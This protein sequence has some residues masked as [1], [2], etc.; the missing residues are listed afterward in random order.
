MQSK[1]RSILVLC[2]AIAACGDT[3]A[4]AATST[5]INYVHGTPIDLDGDG[6]PDGLAI[7]VDGD[8]I[9]DGVDT[10]NDGKVD[11]ALPP[12]PN[13]NGGNSP[14]PTDWTPSSPLPTDDE[15]DPNCRP[16]VV[17]NQRVTPDILIVL[18]RSGSM[19][20]NN[21]WR[22]SVSALQSSINFGLMAFPGTAA[23]MPPPSSD[24]CAGLPLLERLVCQFQNGG[25]SGGWGG[26]ATCEAGSIVVPIEADAAPAISAALDNMA[27]SGNT[28]TSFTLRE[29]HKL[30]G[31]G[32]G[33]PDEQVTPKFV[34]LVTDGEPN[35]EGNSV[36]ALNSTVAAIEEL[37]ADGIRTYVVGYNTQTGQAKQAMD[38][39]AAAGGTGMKEHIAVENEQTLVAALEDITGRAISCTFV[40]EERPD[41]PTYVSVQ[42]DGKPVF[43]NQPNGWTLSDDGKQVLIQGAPCDVLRSPGDHTLVVDVECQAVVPF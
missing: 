28:P 8:G 22:A 33:G 11:L 13:S 1:R 18:D 35:C 2:A 7:D 21:R 23:Q 3:A 20:D 34:L 36:Q 37:A 5:G 32:I 26:P 17:R 25:P 10:D 31:S 12:P 24:P 9:A 41:D 38:R 40:L 30:L 27:P 29:A 42:V 4:P 19:N 14:P 15:E 6:Q 39:M 16:R 43:Y